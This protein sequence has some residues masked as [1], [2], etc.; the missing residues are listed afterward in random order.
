MDWGSGR[1]ETI[2][3][4][5]RQVRETGSFVDRAIVRE[6]KIASELY[7]EKHSAWI[8]VVE[9]VENWQNGMADLRVLDA[10]RHINRSASCWKDSARSARSAAPPIYE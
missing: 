3:Q 2:A 10:V 1:G 5:Q 9:L 7:P 6:V 4:L 8:E